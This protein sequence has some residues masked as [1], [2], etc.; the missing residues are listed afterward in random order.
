MMK[1]IKTM[2]KKFSIMRIIIIIL[3]ILKKRRKKENIEINKNIYRKE[4]PIK[5]WGC[6]NLD[7]Y[8]IINKPIGE[9]AFGTVFKAYYKGPKEYAKKIGIPEIVALK[10][11]KTENEKQGFPI[12]SLREIMIM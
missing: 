11:I 6:K 7:L 9:G 3:K 8:E 2:K 12:T 1:K 4:M 10:K 5:D